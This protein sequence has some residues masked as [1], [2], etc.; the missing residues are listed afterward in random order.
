MKITGKTLMV[1]F[2]HEL[3]IGP[4][5]S[6]ELTLLSNAYISEGKNGNV[7]VDVDLG[8]DFI[9]VKFL[10]NEVDNSFSAFNGWKKSLKNIGIDFNELVEEQEQKLI[11]SGIEDKLKLMFRDKI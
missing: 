3:K 7:E 9:N 6:I 1:A 5:D 11:D 4:N 8:I 10:G 2:E